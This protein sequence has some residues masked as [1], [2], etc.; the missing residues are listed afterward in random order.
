MS[1]PVVSCVESIIVIVVVMVVVMI[2]AAQGLLVCSGPGG[3][4]KEDMLVGIR[5]VAS[6]FFEGDTSYGYGG[7]YKC[8]QRKMIGLA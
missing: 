4:K 5:V 3:E 7:Y 2:A 6:A 8:C 1:L